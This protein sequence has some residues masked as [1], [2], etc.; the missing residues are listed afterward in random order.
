MYVVWALKLMYSLTD[1]QSRMIII[2]KTTISLE[3]VNWGITKS[4]SDFHCK[5]YSKKV[6]IIPTEDGQSFIECESS[7][8]SKTR[9]ILVLAKRLSTSFRLYWNWGQLNFVEMFTWKV[10]SN[11]SIV[12]V[13]SRDQ[14]IQLWVDAFEEVSFDQLHLHRVTVHLYLLVGGHLLWVIIDGLCFK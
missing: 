3:K 7:W 5:Y 9:K 6:Y 10:F 1:Y 13:E 4:L 12:D 14:V 8:K 2:I 11:I